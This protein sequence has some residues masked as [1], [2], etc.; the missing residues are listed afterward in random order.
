M[1]REAELALVG[2]EV[3]TH[4]VGVLGEVD[5]LHG[6]LTKALLS[7][8]GGVAVVHDAAAAELRADAVLHVHLEK[9]ALGKVGRG[10]D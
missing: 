8:A 5:R 2:A 3:V 7:I 10:W 4:E 6:Q 9:G 1:Q